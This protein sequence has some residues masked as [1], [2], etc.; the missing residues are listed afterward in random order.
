A[1]R[2]NEYIKVLSRHVIAMPV[3]KMESTSLSRRWDGICPVGFVLT[4]GNEIRSKIEAEWSAYTTTIRKSWKNTAVPQKSIVF[5]GKLGQACLYAF[6]HNDLPLAIGELF[7]DNYPDSRRRQL[8]L[9][10]LQALYGVLL[11]SY[12]Y[13]PNNKKMLNQKDIRWFIRKTYT[14]FH[15]TTGGRDAL[16]KDAIANFELHQLVSKDIAQM[17]QGLYES[18]QLTWNVQ[19][20]ASGPTLGDFKF[21]LD[22]PK[23]HAQPIRTS[24]SDWVQDA[25]VDPTRIYENTEKAIQKEL[26][27]DRVLELEAELLRP[28]SSE[29]VTHSEELDKLKADLLSAIQLDE[30]SAKR[31]RTG[32]SGFK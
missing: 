17:V 4:V 16:T 5:L 7:I 2:V 10:E 13:G 8:E 12:L 28:E 19:R 21:Y 9:E 3:E 24:P 30:P 14:S 27:I 31:L 18:R 11:R 20:H 32:E 15:K 6:N 29:L 25:K 26:G 1:F 22:Y 23:V